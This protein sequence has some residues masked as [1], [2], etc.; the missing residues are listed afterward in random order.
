[1]HP[2]STQNGLHNLNNSP[3]ARPLFSV[4]GS[5]WPQQK[6]SHA[7]S[8]PAGIAQSPANRNVRPIHRTPTTLLANSKAAPAGPSQGHALFVP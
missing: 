5:P 8:N 1:L 6:L 2:A 4:N 3:A 7:K